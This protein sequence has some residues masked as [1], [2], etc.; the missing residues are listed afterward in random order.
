MCI[1]FLLN[2][3]VY[4][5][6]PPFGQNVFVASY[7]FNRGA[8]ELYRAVFP[9]LLVMALGLVVVDAVPAVSTFAVAHDI[10]LERV[11]A[12]RLHE[13]PRAAWQMECVQD[14]RNDPRPCTDLESRQWGIPRN[15]VEEAD[16]GDFGGAD[17]PE[18]DKA[19][20]DD[21]PR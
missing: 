17:E 2:M 10:A 20:G 21:E 4:N 11:K 5:L 1:M 7:R 12:A 8:V 9:F 15:G 6:T 14:D 13:P 16:T 19:A 3:E 18:L